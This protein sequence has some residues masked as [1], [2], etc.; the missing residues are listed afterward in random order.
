MGGKIIPRIRLTAAKVLVEVKAELGN[1][2]TQ[3][4]SYPKC[5][6]GVAFVNQNF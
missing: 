6:K 2:E 1:N 5:H 4:K 3:Q